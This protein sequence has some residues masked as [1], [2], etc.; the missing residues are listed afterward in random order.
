[1]HGNRFNLMGEFQYIRGEQLPGEI[2]LAKDIGVLALVAMSKNYSCSRSRIIDMLWS[3][4]CDEQARASLRHSLWQLKKFLNASSD[5]LLLIDR[6][7]VSLNPELCSIDATDFFELSESSRRHDLEQAISIYRGDFLEGLVIRDVIWNE[8]L[9][10]ERERL[11]L[12]YAESLFVLSEYYF[13]ARDVKKLIH[14]GRRLIDQDHLCEKGH[15]ALMRA[16]SLGHQKS[17][18]LKQYERYRNTIQAELNSNP[19][20]EIQALYECIKNGEMFSDP[21]MAACW[22]R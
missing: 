21:V 22:I 17:L 18:A 19:E 8:W 13:T 20:P 1:M 16:Y 9:N 2:S 10:I 7:K 4:R 5:D 14:T 12:I 6:K 15:R 11:K 3:D